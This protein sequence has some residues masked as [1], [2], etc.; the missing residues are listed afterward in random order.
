VIV[1]ALIAIAMAAVAVA[2]VL[3]PLLRGH[4][5][6]AQS[7]RE[8]SNA[9]IL[10]DHLRELEAELARGAI[11]EMHYREARSEI[12]RRVL[13]ESAEEPAEMTGAAP[14]HPWVAIGC[15]GL[16]PVVAVLLYLLIGTPEAFVP[17]AAAPDS[18]HSFSREQ[19]EAMVAKLAA[20]LEGEPDNLEGW[21]VLARTYAV[22]QRFP[23][24]AK[25]YERVVALSPGSA[26]ALADYADAAAM[27]QG[28]SLTGEPMKAVERALALDPGHVKALALAGSEAFARKDYAGAVARWEKLRAV[29][30]AGTPMARTVEENIGE[31]R[32][33]GGL[34]ASAPA[35]APTVS[36][37]GARVTGR[38]SLAGPLAGK[39]QPGD[40]VFVF[41]RAAEGPRVPLAV[42]RRSAKELPF[43]FVLDESM[44]MSPER[45]LAAG[46]Q[47]IVG[48]RVSRSGNAIPQS[49]DL[50]GLSAPV[51]VGTSGVEVV[52]DRTVP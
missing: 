32:T 43:D 42:E 13:A 4:G 6:D 3:V 11:D 47:V 16:M 45:K 12:E 5:S 49:G 28:G 46:A 31:A 39:V 51:A 50:E 44:A 29:V 17:Q 26:D 52:I 33:L 37:P 41:A 36:V 21:T 15:A 38:V 18:K 23:E 10:A 14:A 27:A 19:V 8:R 25:A 7:E 35:A 2:W 1:F 20:R 22:M 24:S 40:T 48:V 34:A 30:P 9:A